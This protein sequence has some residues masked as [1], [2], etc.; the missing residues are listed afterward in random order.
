MAGVYIHVP[1][2]YT[3]C[4]Y[5]DFYK[6]TDQAL[7]SNFIS[8]ICKEISLHPSFFSSQKIETI[9]L[10]GGTPS[11]LTIDELKIVFSALQN[12]IDLKSV[13]EITMEVNPDDVSEN[14]IYDLQA[15]GVNRI[16]MGVQ[17]FF[18]AHLRKMNRRHN[19]RQASR[20]VEIVQASGISNMSI[21]LI[22]GLPFMTND[23][24]KENVQ[25]AIQLDVQHVSAY[26]LTIE[27]GT[28]YY[29]YLKKGKI[30]EV[31]E[32]N[33]LIQY[34]YLKSSLLN[35]GYE[36]YEISN[37]SKPSYHSKH[38]S[39]YWTGE[40]YLGLGP[41]AHSF[42]GKV[43]R[44]NVSDM[45][46]YYKGVMNGGTYWKDEK[47]TSFDRYNEIIMVGLRTEKGFE[48]AKL[49][50]YF[51]DDLKAYF[52]T[53]VEKQ[54]AEGGL[55][56]HQGWYFIPDDKRFVTDAIIADLFFVEDDI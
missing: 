43:R 13:T 25:T 2:C 15:L 7:K 51:D 17:S 46:T 38:N 12:H 5:C 56:Y 36:A 48:K 20:A 22:Y 40:L 6:T 26:H 16:S 10:G 52:N 55:V 23:E 9:Y 8:A 21:D 44:W 49:E 11:V 3:R 41:S 42:D 30:K 39:A 34:D 37:F 19:S 29:D 33:S 28:V 54:V 18:D 35:A 45:E 31:D 24:W 27:K 47:L 1:F 14:Y 50:V 53:Q 4:S 32:E